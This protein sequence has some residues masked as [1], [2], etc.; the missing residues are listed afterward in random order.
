MAQAD[1]EQHTT[2]Q[3]LSSH[4]ASKNRMT[5]IQEWLPEAQQKRAESSCR[6]TTGYMDDF[7]SAFGHG[8]DGFW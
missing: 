4:P 6:D 7:R 8:D 2:A 1:G 3:L 5:V